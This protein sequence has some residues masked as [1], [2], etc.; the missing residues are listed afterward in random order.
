[1]H[2]GLPAA[3][4]NG[5]LAPPV[6]GADLVALA[7]SPGARHPGAKLRTSMYSNPNPM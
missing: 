2:P 3:G 7:R 5:G 1:M 4:L 6:G